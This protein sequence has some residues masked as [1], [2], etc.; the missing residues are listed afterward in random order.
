MLGFIIRPID[1]H[2]WRVAREHKGVLMRMAIRR[3]GV[4]SERGFNNDVEVARHD[5]GQGVASQDDPSLQYT[6][7]GGPKITTT[8]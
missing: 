5:N 7:L 4:E 1:E 3:S 8:H 6:V 2:L